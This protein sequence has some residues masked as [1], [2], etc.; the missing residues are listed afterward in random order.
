MKIFLLLL[1]IILNKSLLANEKIYESNFVEININTKNI[2]EDKNREI[3]K[4]KILSLDII[5]NKI[6]N[7]KNINNFKKK[8][9]LQNEINY[10]IKNIIIENE[11]ISNNKY[12]AKVK[13]N[14]DKVEIIELFRKNKINY[15][16]LESSDLMFVAY[17]N[18]SLS[19]E[20]LS[21]NNTFYK[22]VNIKNYGLLNFI[23]P[24]LSLN[25]RFILPYNEIENMS[26][27]N[28]NEFSNKYKT[29]Y[30]IIVKIK[31][32]KIKKDFSI[33]LYSSIKDEIVYISNFQINNNI[34]Y[35][36]QLLSII[37]DWWK[38]LNTIDL[39]IINKQSCLIKNSNIHELYFI[40]SK[41]KS[42]SQI[43]SFNLLKIDLGMNLYDIIYYGDKLNFYS[44]LT[45]KSIK[46]NIDSKKQ[47]ILSL[48]S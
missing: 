9:N 34:N 25:D 39:R 37:N 13:I 44:K 30:L 6:L 16:D 19:K 26:L 35:Q 46:N 18:N 27:S 17:E 33:H 7:K 48:K 1:S 29:N 23:Y 22:K 36:N 32:D 45:N 47:C 15:S 3:E 5:L 10:L 40:I 14:F 24:D 41:I 4:V 21:I 31:N 8:I 28:F 2:A 38:N 11:F 20:G 12:S 43:K 42:I